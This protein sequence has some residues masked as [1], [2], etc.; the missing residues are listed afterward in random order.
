MAVS[1]VCKGDRGFQHPG[2]IFHKQLPLWPTLLLCALPA[3]A[4]NPKKSTGSASAE[5]LAKETQNPI[6]NL[7]SFPLQNNFNFGLGP[8]RVT[9]WVMNVQ[10]VIPVPL[11]R[12]WNLI[13]HTILPVIDQPSIAPEAPSSFGLGDLKPTFTLPT[14][15]DR[16]IGQQMWCAGPAVVGLT[17]QGP[18]VVGALA[19]QQSTVS[20][21]GVGVKIIHLGRMP[22]NLSLAAFYN[23]ET[24]QYGSTWY[25]GSQSRCSS[26]DRTPAT[27]RR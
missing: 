20:A 24:P 25:P 13:T 2:V 16:L 7:I 18:W 9:Q 12:D 5:A 23:M 3:V 22:L 15:T 21:S 10:P 17:M 14:A 27:A 4:E 1:W 11:D 26:Q 19:R 6:A 8:S